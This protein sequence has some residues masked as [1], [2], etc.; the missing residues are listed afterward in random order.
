MAKQASSAVKAS[1]NV[2]VIPL[3]AFLEMF[4]V[5]QKKLMN[6]FLVKVVMLI[7]GLERKFRT[8]ISTM[9]PLRKVFRKFSRVIRNTLEIPLSL[10]NWCRT[11][12][13]LNA[14]KTLEV[15][16]VKV[17]MESFLAA[18]TKWPDAAVARKPCALDTWRRWKGK[19]AL[20]RIS[21]PTR[22]LR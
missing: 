11:I 9:D 7:H 22:P 1:F 5:S 21:A 12:K 18:V 13:C 8:L 19:H 2:T 15:N 3:T 10:A 6:R 4:L 14:R 17:Q 16:T 20:A